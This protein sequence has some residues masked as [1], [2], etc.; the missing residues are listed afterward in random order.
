[1]S[2][3]ILH[4][5]LFSVLAAMIGCGPSEAPEP[6][7][8]V[9]AEI[10]EVEA[11]APEREPPPESAPPRDM[12]FPESTESEQK[13]GLKV[14][15]LPSGALPVLYAQL[16]I[17]SGSATAPEARPALASLVAAMLEQGTKKKS[18]EKLAEAIE[19]LGADLSV[20]ADPDSLV[21]TIRALSEHLDQAIAL[22]AE[23]ATQPSFD[24][25]ELGKLKRREL[26]RLKLAARSPEYLARRAFYAELYGDHPYRAIDTTED[27]V[28]AVTRRELVDWHAAHVVPNN[29]FLVVAGD[30]EEEALEKT[31]EKAF[32]AWKP[33]EVPAP[34]SPPI[35]EP[36]GRRVI[37][38]DRPESVQSAIRIG[39]LAIPR[40]SD[41]WIPLEVANEV[42][43]GSASSRLFM[44]LREKRS[45]TYG[46][47][48]AVA[49]RREPGAF[50]AMAQVR[51]EVT[52][53]AIEAFFEHLERIVAEAPPEDELTDARNSLSNS[54]PLSIETTGKIVG[55]VTK[56]ELYGLAPDYWSTY[57]TQV[58]E[59]GPE[60]ALEQ[61]RRQIR[62]E[63]ALVVVV[64]RTAD[65]VEPL[66]KL[67]PVTL[68][69]VDGKVL[70]TLDAVE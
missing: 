17:R 60:A 2:R 19:F 28:K 68:M 11:P 61:A 14:L 27:A 1:M 69:D 39:N 12:K 22:L 7:P 38:I 25:K 64:G 62:P 9:G 20:S 45:F 48:S 32:R 51:N 56:R 49:Q 70:K 65:L 23:V 31:V 4:A 36:T 29:A 59:V 34:S 21:I 3:S 63:S 55:L 46:A 47:Y 43:G 57:R 37:L 33:R 35:P 50:A 13:N 10:A 41:A 42:L 16:V 30:F 24:Q 8:T 53:P 5:S 58:L 52:L 66:R 67:G 26:D 40:A 15:A 18:A 54:F 6:E 44:D